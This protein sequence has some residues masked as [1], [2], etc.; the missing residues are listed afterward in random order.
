MRNHTSKAGRIY[1]NIGAA[2]LVPHRLRD[3]A[4]LRA[5]L[6]RQIHRTMTATWQLGDQRGGAVGT[7]VV[8]DH[9]SR[10]RSSE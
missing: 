1:Q 3:F 8:A 4:D 7:L 2:A 6:H 10:T 5:I 9:H